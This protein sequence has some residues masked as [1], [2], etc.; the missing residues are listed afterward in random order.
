[1]CIVLNTTK[2]SDEVRKWYDEEHV[3]LACSVTR[4][5]AASSLAFI[6]CQGQSQLKTNF[7]G[8]VP[9]KL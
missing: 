9:G 7:S 5:E 4:T 8:T 3:L 1:M 2:E 6:Q